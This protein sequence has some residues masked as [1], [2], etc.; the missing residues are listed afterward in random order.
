MN[1]INKP[2]KFLLTLN[3]TQKGEMMNTA[4]K[5]ATLFNTKDDPRIVFF[6]GALSPEHLDI[7]LSLRQH[8]FEGTGFQTDQLLP[9][10]T[11]LFRPYRASSETGGGWLERKVEIAETLLE[12]VSPKKT[13]RSKLW[14]SQTLRKNGQSLYLGER[15]K[16]FLILLMGLVPILYFAA[17]HKDSFAKKKLEAKVAA[18][19]CTFVKN[20]CITDTSR[21]IISRDCFKP[22]EQCPEPMY[23]SLFLLICIPLVMVLINKISKARGEKIRQLLHEEIYN[24]TEYDLML[25]Q[26]CE[27]NGLTPSWDWSDQVRITGTIVTM[28]ALALI[29]LCSFDDQIYAQLFRHTLTSAHR[30]KEIDSFRALGLT[31][32]E[33]G[34]TVAATAFREQATQLQ[35]DRTTQTAAPTG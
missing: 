7:L 15:E 26:L 14:I 10:S 6:M 25:N 27:K 29:A 19:I 28:R 35:Q 21:G 17:S 16:L 4:K 24:S 33:P 3:P 23:V 8:L 11:L 20:G 9:E 34:A 13:T 2:A 1:F 32:P 18:G 30:T 31:R 22:S 12:V 5:L